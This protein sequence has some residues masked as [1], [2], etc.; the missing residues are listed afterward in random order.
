M[1][2]VQLVHPLRAWR[3]RRRFSAA[4]VSALIEARG[5]AFKR[6]SVL[7]VEDGWR[8]PA[9][10]ICEVIQAITDGEVTIA[11]LRHWPLR[12]PKLDGEAA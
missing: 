3:E 11:V 9:Y 8:H 6:R 5:F 2:Q 1:P 4:D 10:D 7:A 12:Q